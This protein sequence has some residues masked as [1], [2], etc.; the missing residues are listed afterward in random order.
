V[1]AVDERLILWKILSKKRK[2]AD[3]NA[4]VDRSKPD[5]VGKAERLAMTRLFEACYKQVENSKDK[6]G[7]RRCL[8]FLEIP[9]KKLY[10]DYYVII[11]TPIALDIIN[12]R[13]HSTYYDTVQDFINDFRLMFS[14]ARKYN[15]ETSLVYLDSIE[16][17]KEMDLKLNELYKD[18]K[19]T[20]T[21]EDKREEQKFLEHQKAIKNNINSLK[22]LLPSE[23]NKITNLNNNNNGIVTT[24]IIENKPNNSNNN[25]KKEEKLEVNNKIDKFEKKD[26]SNKNT[27]SIVQEP[28]QKKQKRYEDG[29]YK[30][31]DI[32]N[33]YDNYEENVY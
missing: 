11:E 14:N 9:S 25:N 22:R 5:K 7:R 21:D 26:K 20:I 13:I 32:E 3:I 31:V 16:M 28:L 18:Q 17:E 4:N 15:Q 2:K 24:L 30:D 27:D 8:L 29:E 12:T 1:V 10:P 19:L 33:D 6:D 23:E